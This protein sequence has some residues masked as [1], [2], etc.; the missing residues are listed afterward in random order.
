L[1]A[2]EQALA[3]FF[4]IQPRLSRFRKDVLVFFLHMVLDVFAQHFDLGVEQRILRAAAFYF[5]NQLF[6]AAVFNRGFIQGIVG[7][8]VVLGLSQFRIK[9]LFFDGGVR[10]ELPADLLGKIALFLCVV[11]VFV[12]FEKVEHRVVIGPQDTQRVL[13]YRP[14]LEP[15]FDPGLGLVCAAFRAAVFLEADFRVAMFCLRGGWLEADHAALI[16]SAQPVPVGL[17][18]HRKKLCCMQLHANWG[19]LAPGL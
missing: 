9:D 6:S 11:A 10:G 8:L 12:L 14:D 19:D 7:L 3:H 16:F 4:E 17:F 13:A 18:S 5:C 15:R 1:L 2:R